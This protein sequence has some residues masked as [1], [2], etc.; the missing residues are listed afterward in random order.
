[1]LFYV[2]LKFKS[3]VYYIYTQSLYEA[4]LFQSKN[5]LPKNY[6]LSN[7]IP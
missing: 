7:K 1:M 5:A 3:N 2:Y 4:M 6:K